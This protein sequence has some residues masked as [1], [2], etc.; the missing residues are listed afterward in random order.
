MEMLDI[1]EN[2][3]DIALK[4]GADGAEAF[5]LWEKSVGIEIEKNSIS[6]SSRAAIFGVGIR[7]IK[8][9]KIGF[10]YC[11]DISKIKESVSDAFSIS[12]LSKKTK[13]EFSEHT[14]QKKIAKTYDKKIVD[15][16]LEEVVENVHEMI[17]SAKKIHKEVTVTSGG[18]G[19]GYGGFALVNSNGLRVQ[20]NGT[21]I[22]G[23]ANVILKN[24]GVSTGFESSVSR[25]LSIDFK[26]IGRTAAEIALKGRS[27]KKF[28]SGKTTVLFTPH[29]IG[30]L[31]E[32]IVIPA[33]YADAAKKGESIFSSKV[34][35]IVM[36]E[37]FSIIDDGS[38]EN[39]VNSA[40]CDDEGVPS[41]RVEIIKNGVL[42]N[43]LYDRGT[44]IEYEEESTSS[45]IRSE[46]LL[47]SRTFKSI[48]KII[49]RNVMLK[50]KTYA[51]EKMISEVKDG[52]VVY[53][54][55]GGHTANPVSGDF[56]V[57]STILFRI[58]NGE[59]KHGLKPVM[60][61]GNM[62]ECLKNITM[63]GNDY[64]II[65]GQLSPVGMILPTVCIE[66]V[67]VTA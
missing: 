60:L 48:P 8:D 28:E 12:T 45:G 44:A 65:A 23:N 40:S 51:L 58:E 52:I 56:S 18:V 33:F 9:R 54:I 19:F 17:E 39:G 34:N 2:V 35:K 63:I 25:I 20:N 31:F 53:D 14:K 61:S 32:F 62:K 38:M 6:S 4:L 59:I 67:R 46:R 10:S 21:S 64:K 11:T 66:R 47:S 37:D 13:F 50:G 43:Y 27:A 55:L 29:A 30:S 3:I 5:L 49:G 15:L 36:P 24:E 1:G 57:N 42:K 41:R 22:A 16:E 26:N 7:I